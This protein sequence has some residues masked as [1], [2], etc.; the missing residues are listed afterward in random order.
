MILI[1]WLGSVGIG[2]VWG[3]WMGRLIFMSHR[4]SLSSLF[5]G[6]G[7]ILPSIQIFILSDWQS[8]VV[9]LGAAG[10]ALLVHLEWLRRLRAHVDQFQRRGG[11]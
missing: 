1:T 9:F 8:L 4:R 10:F 2:L 6:L 5:S 11:H 7:T 3:W